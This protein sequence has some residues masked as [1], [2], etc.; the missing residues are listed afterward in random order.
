MKIE[1]FPI[2]FHNGCINCWPPLDNARLTVCVGVVDFGR[3]PCNVDKMFQ[4]NQKF[5]TQKRTIYKNVY[6]N[7]GQFSET[8]NC[9]FA[10]GITKCQIIQR[11]VQR[12]FR[13]FIHSIEFVLIDEIWR[14]YSGFL[15][16][17]LFSFITYIW[18]FFELSLSLRWQLK[19]CPTDN[20]NFVY[21]GV[22][23]FSFYFYL[24]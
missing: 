16:N 6:H 5:K 7:F 20:E 10:D 13:N 17:R 14:K 11:I 15:W 22:K 19:G 18:Y 4:F 23:D 8:G 12:H 2:C 24:F 9:C 21:D 3:I 1:L